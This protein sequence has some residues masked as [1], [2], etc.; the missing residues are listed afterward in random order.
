MN[1]DIKNPV[2]CQD[3]I[4]ISTKLKTRFLK[5]GIFLPIGDYIVSPE[6]IKTLMQ[7]ETKD[8]HCLTESDL[9]NTDKMNFIAIDK[10][11]SPK[12][13]N[14]LSSVDVNKGKSS[15]KAV[16]NFDP[17]YFRF[18]YRQIHNHR[19]KDLPFLVSNFLYT[20]MEA[21]VES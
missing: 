17:I 18:L 12:V 10:L 6:Y 15:H 4:H 5:E 11:S 20:N 14:L 1:Y 16:F 13:T 21:L 2:Y 7:N 19:T 8:K 3:R 9:N